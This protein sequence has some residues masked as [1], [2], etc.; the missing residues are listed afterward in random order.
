MQNYFLTIFSKYF[1]INNRILKIA[2]GFES[3]ESE[4]RESTQRTEKNPQ[5]GGVVT[6]N[7]SA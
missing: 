1:L 2:V 4:G 3:S 7:I 6:E 5:D